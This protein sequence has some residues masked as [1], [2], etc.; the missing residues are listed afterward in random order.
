MVVTSFLIQNGILCSWQGAE[1]NDWSGGKLGV[2]MDR[3]IGKLCGPKGLNG[4]DHYNRD[5]DV[6]P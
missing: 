2:L 3:L 6:R 5:D 4:C 1:F